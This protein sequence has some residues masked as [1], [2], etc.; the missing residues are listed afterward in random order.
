MIRAFLEKE[1]DT[2]A[3]IRFNVTDTGIGIPQNRKH[4]IFQSFSQVDASTTRK[5]GGT[6][7]GLAISKKL[8][9]KMNGQIG[10]ESKESQGSTFWFSIEFEKQPID[11]NFHVASLEEIQKQ[12]ILIVDDNAMNRRVLKEQLKRWE[13]S[14]DEASSADQAVHTMQQAH[15]AGRPF[16]IAILDLMMPEIDGEMLGRKIKADKNL[17]DIT[18]IMLTSIGMRGDASRM[19][20]A[21]FDAYLTKPIKR[22]SLLDC[23]AIVLGKKSNTRKNPSDSIITRYTIKNSRRFKAKILLAEDN[24]INQKVTIQ[25]LKKHG[26]KA[27]AVSN[28]REAVQALEMIAYDVVLMDVQMPEMDGFEATRTI[29]NPG[30]AVINHKIPVIAITAHAL[31]GDK[32]RCLENGMDDYVSK[33][34]E[35]QKLLQAIDRQLSSLVA[36]ETDQGPDAEITEHKTF[37]FQSLLKRLNGDTEIFNEV[38]AFFLD[39]FTAQNE[40]LKTLIRQ[41]RREEA[42]KIANSLKDTCSNVDASVLSE[43]AMEI[44]HTCHDQ[45]ADTADQLIKKFDQRFE[46]FKSALSSTGFARQPREGSPVS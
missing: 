1:T 23:L 5:Y 22:S 36:P 29:R 27:D 20:E 17:Q 43:I 31:K 18:L 41:G 8:V 13:C 2:H 45:Q 46:E 37:D 26:F 10:V 12:R 33:P 39:E 9:Q 44:E 40:E 35:P 4:H 11:Q 28:G 21:G 32:E 19:K 6:G 25:I 30:S 38:M 16:S 24:M 15:Q 34:I 3:M 7:L 42:E 14:F